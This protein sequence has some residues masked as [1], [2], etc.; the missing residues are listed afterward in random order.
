MPINDTPTIARFFNNA[1]QQLSS[2]KSFLFDRYSPAI[3]SG[4]STYTLPNYV[5]SIAA[6]YWKGMLLDPLT[7]RNHREVFQSATQQ[8]TPFWYLFDNI[9]QNKIQFFPAPNV[10]L[11]AVGSDLWNVAGTDNYTG[12]V[13][14]E[15][16][17][18]TDNSSFIVPSF[19]RRQLLKYYV[20]RQVY[21]KDGAG[22]NAKL[23][24][25]FNQKWDAKKQEFYSWLDEMY[26]K[27]RKVIVQELVSN[28]YFPASP[29]LPIAKYGVSVSE[30]E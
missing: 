27:P 14:I 28:N 11:S 23:R 1:E 30:G 3:T 25:Y 18:I 16:A 21:S 9:G 26:L 17:R 6:V 22:H 24:D 15:F 10:N 20:A 4:T 8:G 12:G 19:L 5:Q 29:V 13:I 2:E 7:R